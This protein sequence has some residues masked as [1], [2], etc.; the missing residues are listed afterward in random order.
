MN[1]S[2]TTTVVTASSATPPNAPATMDPTDRRDPTG[3]GTDVAGILAGILAGLL[4]VY[5]NCANPIDGG[6][7]RNTE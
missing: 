6:V 3:G 7:A 1:T 4:A 2:K 5:D